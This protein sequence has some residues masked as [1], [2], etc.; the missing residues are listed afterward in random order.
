MLSLDQVEIVPVLR[1]KILGVGCLAECREDRVTIRR[2]ELENDTS[3]LAVGKDNF[4]LS[5]LPCCQR[6][7]DVLGS[8]DMSGSMTSEEFRRT[9]ERLKMTQ[10]EMAD[11][12]DYH[13][14]AISRFE[15]GVR[16]ISAR[17]AKA[18]RALKRLPAPSRAARRRA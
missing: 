15:M 2:S 8:R 6:Q 16:P 4:H 13:Y 10:S 5:N 14:S 7:D 17:V 9:R 18:V 3:F 12:L 11:A 1:D